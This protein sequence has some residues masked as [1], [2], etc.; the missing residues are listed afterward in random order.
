MS[1]VSLVHAE[2][3]SE[4]ATQLGLDRVDI[5]KYLPILKFDN[6][7]DTI[8]NLLFVVLILFFIVRVIV[9]GIKVGGAG[10]DTAKR[11]EAIKGLI[12]AII[13]LVISLLA[14]VITNFVLG[15][16]GVATPTSIL[17]DCSQISDTTSRQTCEKNNQKLTNKGNLKNSTDCINSG[18]VWNNKDKV[19]E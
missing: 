14:L 12:N 16:L 4:I 11:Q 10:G 7:I 18:G 2:T 17:P 1:S 9:T 6:L 13:G 5:T 8:L 3:N 15:F 19:C